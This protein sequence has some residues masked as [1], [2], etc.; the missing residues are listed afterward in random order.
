MGGRV[1]QISWTCCAA[2]WPAQQHPAQQHR[3]WLRLP[4][5]P[6][7]RDK[8][9]AGAANYVLGMTFAQGRDGK[10]RFC[11]TALA[12]SKSVTWCCTLYQAKAVREEV[13]FFQAE[14][15]ILGAPGDRQRVKGGSP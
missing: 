3:A 9:L 12:L 4:R 1:R 5:L 6:D 14:K 2:C 10:W 15:V 7:G 11:D 13:A 8:T